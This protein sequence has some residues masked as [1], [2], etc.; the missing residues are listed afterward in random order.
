MSTDDEDDFARR[1]REKALVQ[2]KSGDLPEKQSTNLGNEAS[3]DNTVVGFVREQ[4]FKAGMKFVCRII[5]DEP[6]G[7][8]IMIVQ[9]QT[10][11]FLPTQDLLEIGEQF[12]A[13]FVC[14]HNGR[15]L[16]AARFSAKKKKS[17]SNPFFEVKASELN[18]DD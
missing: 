18:D 16:V 8:S 2:N 12:L 3:V 5:S 7:Y 17:K 11:G 4:D 13:Q 14:V 10:P 9:S 6:G 15:I 1:R